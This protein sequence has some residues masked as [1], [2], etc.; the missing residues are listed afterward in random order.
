MIDV[1]II[2][3]SLNPQGVRITSFILTYHRFIHCEFLTHRMFSRNAASSRAIPV[4]KII[5]NI[6]ECPA[7]PLYWGKNQ[8]GMQADDELNETD[9]V[10]A[11]QIWLE[12]LESQIK[13]ANRLL[14]LNVHKQ[15]ANRLLEP[16]CHITSLLTATEFGN[17]FNLRAHKDAQP[18]F[19]ELAFQMLDAYT[20]PEQSPK[21]LKEGEWHL[22]FADKY[23][24]NGLD[25][26][27]L[28]KITTA[29]AARLSYLTFEGDIAY[30][31]DYELHDGLAKNGHWSPFEHAAQAKNDTKFYANF[32]GFEQY[33]KKFERENQVIFNSD[34]LKA[35]R[36]HVSQKNRME[37]VD[38]PVYK[39]GER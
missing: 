21:Q 13:Y 34:V 35:G 28:L 12:S 23:I 20:S 26:N 27:S 37:K 10:L 19:Q 15:I 22:P 4:N 9:S 24:E 39:S 38:R 16:F 25:T 7:V 11:E 30:Q 8:K 2:A 6:R 5:S 31:K 14:D 33:R 32:R 3:D 17:F 29:R 18:E 1:R 36:K